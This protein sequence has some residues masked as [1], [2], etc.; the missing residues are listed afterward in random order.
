MKIIQLLLVVFLL[1]TC[2]CQA[3][4]LGSA[5]RKATETTKYIIWGPK[6]PDM[7][8]APNPLLQDSP[9]IIE[10]GEVGDG[11]LD[12]NPPIIIHFDAVP[13]PGV[14]VANLE[15]PSGPL[16]VV[17]LPVVIDTSIVDTTNINLII[18]QPQQHHQ[19]QQH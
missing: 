3:S 15:Q 13:I 1:F 10:V 19:P 9:D 7:V 14:P 6:K 8:V 12:G 4:F 17:A 5:W 18:N 2:T 11:V 16:Q